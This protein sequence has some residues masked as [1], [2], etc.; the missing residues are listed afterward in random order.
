MSH[1]GIKGQK[2]GTSGII[3]INT[4][5]DVSRCSVTICYNLESLVYLRQQP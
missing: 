1:I 5:L 4:R 3:N 2:R